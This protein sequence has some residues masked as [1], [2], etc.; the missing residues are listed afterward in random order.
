MKQFYFTF[1]S[2][3]LL[4]NGY[5]MHNNWVRVQ[6]EDYDKARHLFIEKFSSVFMERPMGWSFQYDE[7]AFDASFF[8][9]GEYLLLI[10]E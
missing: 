10:Q 2:N 7:E 3:H 1:G 4:K 6:A 9:K 5:A 8:P